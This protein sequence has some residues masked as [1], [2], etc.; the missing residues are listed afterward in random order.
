[1]MALEAEATATDNLAVVGSE[2][3]K[4]QKIFVC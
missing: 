4:Q 2:K 3:Q 1:M